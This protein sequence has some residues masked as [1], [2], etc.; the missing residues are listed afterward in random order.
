MRG[1]AANNVTLRGTGKVALSLSMSLTSEVEF[2][3]ALIFLKTLFMLENHVGARGSKLQEMVLST[4]FEWLT[5]QKSL[6]NQFW[7][8]KHSRGNCK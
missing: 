5:P 7:K 2:H 8:K 3:D 6:E 4:Q 1:C